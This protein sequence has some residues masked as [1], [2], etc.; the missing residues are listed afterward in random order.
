MLA[1]TDDDSG[2]LEAEAETEVETEGD[3]EVGAEV[4]AEIEAE[5]GVDDA[6]HAQDPWINEAAAALTEDFEGVQAGA[7]QDETSDANDA[8]DAAVMDGEFEEGVES[9]GDVG[10]A[11]AALGGDA[12]GETAAAVEEEVEETGAGSEAELDA[13]LDAESDAAIDSESGAASAVSDDRVGSDITSAGALGD[14]DAEGEDGEGAA[15]QSLEDEGLAVLRRLLDDDDSLGDADDTTDLLGMAA[16][17]DGDTAGDF[18]TAVDLDDVHVDA[19][20]E[21]KA[22]ADAEAGAELDDNN[23][24][25]NDDDEGDIAGRSSADDPASPQPNDVDD[26]AAELQIESQVETQVDA[27]AD[28]QQP[29]I[30]HDARATVPDSVAS[31]APADGAAEVDDQRLVDEELA[32][33]DQLMQ[34]AEV[35]G[36]FE[37][38]TPRPNRPMS[39]LDARQDTPIDPPEIIAP[40]AATETARAAAVAAATA[41]DGVATVA[42]DASIEDAVAT[43]RQLWGDQSSSRKPRRPIGP[44]VLFVLLPVAALAVV[45]RAS[46]PFIVESLRQSP[47][48]VVAPALPADPSPA[49]STP[50]AEVA[51]EP[52]DPA[53]TFDAI[54]N[55]IDNEVVP[56]SPVSP[57]AADD[58]NAD[59]DPDPDPGTDADA[60]SDAGRDPATDSNVD[61]R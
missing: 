42:T 32:L 21:L 2:R 12:D 45:L 44:I 27:S 23:S 7:E 51:P 28:V 9:A 39:P 19:T 43:P 16:A 38:H 15:D 6:V 11:G 34:Q 13:E 46:W 20:P 57:D 17:D 5:V 36:D 40:E 53:A 33:V 55:A 61:A 58:S 29:D 47:P 3:S 31:A 30:A 4:E 56:A 24:D 52:V 37:I 14:D 48:T 60:N 49:T 18:E 8:N 25:N 1:L 10:A 22:D 35:T 59:P 26:H 50:P 54:L 41:T